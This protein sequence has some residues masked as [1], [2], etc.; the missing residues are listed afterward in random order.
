M[1]SARA[2]KWVPTFVPIHPTDHHAVAPH[3]PSLIRIISYNILA[4]AYVKS[5]LFPHSPSSCLRWKARSEAILERLLSFD[6]DFL[7]LQELDEFESF[8]KWK[9]DE[10]GYS[11]VYVQRS[12]RKRDGCGIFFR[13]ARVQ[14]VEEQAIDYNDLVPP[15]PIESDKTV[16]SLSADLLKDS[17]SRNPGSTW[18]EGRGDPSDPRVR[19]KRDCVALL[20]AFRLIDVP[21]RIFILGNT[22][23]YWDPEWP[24]VKLAQ[25]CYL[26]SWLVKFKESIQS[27][28]DSP[29]L[30]VITGD[31]NSLPGDQVPRYH[32]PALQLDLRDPRMTLLR[33]PLP[34]VSLYGLVQGVHP[35]TNVTPG[36]TG[37]IDYI[38]FYPSDC[39]QP[40]SLLALPLPGAPDIQGG[41]PNHTHPSDHLPIGA[42]LAVF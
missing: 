24:D 30:L 5:S 16:P 17:N 35:N 19:L 21:T 18:P 12:G 42:D 22:Q 25:A 33:A 40:R 36:F 7:C 28:S 6:A 14:L 3:P 2:S 32:L 27:K 23:L 20:A 13:R 10:H 37:P 41:L 1:M 9:L 4:Q 31:Y 34:L 39:L 15:S 38:F 8:Y 29:P 11:S 26:L